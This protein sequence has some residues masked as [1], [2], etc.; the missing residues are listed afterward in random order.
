M[1]NKIRTALLMQNVVTWVLLIIIILVLIY[2]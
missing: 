2:K 1:L